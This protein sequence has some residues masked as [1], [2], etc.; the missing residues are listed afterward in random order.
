MIREMIIM[1]NKIKLAFIMSLLITGQVAASSPLP[2]F[3]KMRSQSI[4]TTAQDSRK[5]S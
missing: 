1:E 3:D 4:R 2:T 5:Y